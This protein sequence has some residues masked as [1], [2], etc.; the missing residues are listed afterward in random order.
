MAGELA[1]L[2][3][4]GAFSGPITVQLAPGASVEHVA[5]A[6]I[7]YVDSADGELLLDAP[8]VRV[9]LKKGR[10]VRLPFVIERM[11]LVN[12]SAATVN[13]VLQAG[14]VVIEDHGDVEI[15]KPNQLATAADV[16]VGVA[17]TQILASNLSR[18]TAILTNRGAT[19]VRIGPQ[20]TVATG[21]GHPLRPGQS[22]VLNGS[23]AIY[24]IV[25][26]GTEPVAVLEQLRA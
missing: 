9:T 26:A 24:G 4:A 15:T 7:L 1:V 20:A 18:E 8:R 21:A 25:A 13:M 3:E 11:R 23:A 22:L 17:A 5:N 2:A 10:L 14:N 6:R 19:D 12:Q 16:V